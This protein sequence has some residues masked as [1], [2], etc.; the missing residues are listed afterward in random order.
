MLSGRGAVRRRGAFRR[1]E[2]AITEAAEVRLED[3]AVRKQ[4]IVML[5]MQKRCVSTDRN[6]GYLCSRGAFRRSE[7]ADLGACYAAEVRFDGPKQLIVR[8]R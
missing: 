8:M 1:F 7:T 6:D 3:S 5:V 2:T 4:L